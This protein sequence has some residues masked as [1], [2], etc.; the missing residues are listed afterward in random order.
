MEHA[1]HRALPAAAL[2]INLLGALLLA[3]GIAALV[4]PE[5]G[6]TIPALGDTLTAWSLIGV[7]LVLDFW[8]I[9]AIVQGRRSSE[10]PS[11]S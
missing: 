1:D 2:A 3:A 4:L 10:R 5:I 8:S 7:G 9:V 6:E 11:G